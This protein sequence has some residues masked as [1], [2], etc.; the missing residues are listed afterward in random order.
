MLLVGTAIG[1]RCRRCCRCCGVWHATFTP[2][3]SCCDVSYLFFKLLPCPAEKK[4][5]DS[6]AAKGDEQKKGKVL[7][8]V[9]KKELSDYVK[10]FSNFRFSI[11]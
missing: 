9:D 10:R 8:I 7:R 5:A 4:W 11:F 3:Q 6:A 1:C 2:N